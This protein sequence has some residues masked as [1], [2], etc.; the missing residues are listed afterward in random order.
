[1]QWT[2]QAP[3][4]LGGVI[5]S[6]E[7]RIFVATQ[8]VE[9][10]VV[11]AYEALTGTLLWSEVWD[12][13]GNVDQVRSIVAGPGA[14]VVVGQRAYGEDIPGPDSQLIVR[15]YDPIGG[16]ALW[17]DRV[18][19]YDHSSAS[20]VAVSRNRVFVLCRI[21]HDDEPADMLLRAYNASSGRLIW[22]TTRP[23]T[24]A[25][26]IEAS[27]GRV[28][29]AGGAL[30]GYL[31]AFD[32]QSGALLWEDS[33]SD[34]NLLHLAV[35]GNRVAV[36]GDKAIGIEYAL[37]VRVY[38]AS[39]GIMGWEDQPRLNLGH[40][41]HVKGVAINER[42]V[43]VAG[44]IEDTAIPNPNRMMLVRAYEAGTGTLLWDDRSHPSQ[45]PAG[46]ND[47]ALGTNPLVV[48]GTWIPYVPGFDRI[49]RRDSG[50]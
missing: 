32:E 4:Y 21:A 25:Q 23:A 18:R 34:G 44:L 12:A 31:G 48:L 2:V 33:V 43:Y 15:A 29:V 36:A 22:E 11:R 19:R 27:A 26:V 16:A 28:F 20:A 39:S 46:W 8:T 7:G 37:I 35:E 3:E 6:S 9:G 1:M 38:D 45:Y 41:G 42:A 14:V 30:V 47:M 49:V 5:A 24:P 13:G 10:I 17:D 40:E 50:L